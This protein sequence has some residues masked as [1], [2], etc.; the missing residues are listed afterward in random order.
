VLHFTTQV[1]E[2]LGDEGY[3]DGVYTWRFGW[4]PLEREIV[5]GKWDNGMREAVATYELNFTVPPGVEVLAG[6]LEGQLRTERLREVYTGK[7]LIR[8]RSLPIVLTARHTSA[9]W[10]GTGI[11]VKSYFLPGHERLGTLLPKLAARILRDYQEHYGPYPYK[12]LDIVEHSGQGVGMSADGIVLLPTD[13]YKYPDLIIPG[14]YDRMME[15]L[16]AHEI[17][18]HYWGIGIGMDLDAENWLSEGFAEYLSISYF[19][20]CYGAEGN[21]LFDGKDTLL[22]GLMSYWLGEQN[23]RKNSEWGYLSAYR[24]DMDEAIVKPSREVKYQNTVS[25]RIYQKGYLVLRAL[26]DLVG[27]EQMEDILRQAYR[28]YGQNPAMS[29]NDLKQIAQKVTGQSLEKY[30]Q[31]WLYNDYQWTDYAVRSLKSNFKGDAWQTEV[32]V[33]R[34]G[35]NVQPVT[36]RASC[37]DGTA[38]QVRWSGEQTRQTLTFQTASKVERVEIDPDQMLLDV[39]RLNNSQPKK[40]IWTMDND[41]SL[42]SYVMRYFPG[43]VPGDVL[44]GSVDSYAMGF[45]LSG[46]VR[47]NFLVDAFQIYPQDP[48][49]G[50]RYPLRGAQFSYAQGRS[51]S[52]GGSYLEALGDKSGL[53]SVG[54]SVWRPV[55][56]GQSG[57]YWHPVHNF[58]AAV[59]EEEISGS[60]DRT[61][62][63]SYTRDDSLKF[64]MI[65]A[66]TVLGY[67][68]GSRAGA[69][70]WLK[71]SRPGRNTILATAANYSASR[72]LS[73]DYG[74]ALGLNSFPLEVGHFRAGATAQLVAPLLQQQEGHFMYGT[75]FE[76]IEAMLYLEAGGVW[77]DPAQRSNSYR[78]GGGAEITFGFAMGDLSGSASPVGL[79]IGIAAPIWSAAGRMPRGANVYFEV[80]M[81][82][83]RTYL[84]I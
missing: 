14:L 29:V 60:K 83:F 32:V 54:Y 34:K 69:W 6:G 35:D 36:V 23:Y 33:E 80:G 50:N 12:E 79:T 13:V 67:G 75:L 18:H 45:G 26:E 81:R 58:S 72:G 24:A 56:I 5:D 8:Q 3:D 16:L 42:D 38:H 82:Y 76:D 59:L 51:F 40:V 78:V 84:G 65:N 55:D 11:A 53:L 10:Q 31:S 74:F 63:L 46:R 48:E 4:Y 73:S 1:P 71:I 28:E 22:G 77:D 47:N 17:A 25:N 64:A 57:T 66:F 43:I 37:Q 52:A 62:Q 19:E 49:N 20:R 27:L 21:N 61:W 68:D 39:D 15:G 2:R 9:T 70:D 41:V 44:G 30:F 7:S